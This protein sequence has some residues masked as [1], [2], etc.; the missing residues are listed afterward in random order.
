[1]DLKSMSY[2]ETTQKSYEATAEAFAQNV[3]HLA[4]HESIEH[5]SKLLPINAKLLDLGCG[6][7]RDAKLFS[8][9]GLDVTGIDFSTHLLEIAKKHAPLAHFKLMDI[10]DLHFAPNSFDGIWAACSLGHVP[11]DKLPEV[12]KKIHTLLKENGHFYI[13][14]K[15]GA[16]EEL[17]EDTRYSDHPKKFWAFYKENELNHLLKNAGFTINDSK[18]VK[19]KDPYLTHDAIRIFCMK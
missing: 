4:P 8:E 16:S 17:I 18:T 12:L 15:E 2:K 19:S 11:K 6:S 10:E 14:L 5:F 1:M 13:A 3:A 7:G 9:K